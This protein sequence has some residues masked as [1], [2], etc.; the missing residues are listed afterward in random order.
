MREWSGLRRL[1]LQA[2]GR[3][4]DTVPSPKFNHE[5][6]GAWLSGENW[7]VNVTK[8]IIRTGDMVFTSLFSALKK[9]K[10]AWLII[11]AIS[12][13]T[14]SP[15]R[16][17]IINPTEKQVNE[18]LVYGKKHKDNIE[19]IK[20][21][22]SYP[23]ISGKEEFVAVVTKV[24]LLK[25]LSAYNEK[26]GQKLSEKDIEGIVNA[27]S[28]YIKAYLLGDDVDFAADIRGVIK[29]GDRVIQPVEVKPMVW[30]IPSLAWPQSP[31]YKA[32]NYYYFDYGEKRGDEK[33]TFILQKA[34]GEKRFEIDL[35]KYD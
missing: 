29:I 24:S 21:E 5:L 11:T 13:I 25:L 12:L 3:S 23:L 17:M 27:K 7:F 4:R 19:K 2:K 15:S 14:A 30:A 18:A 16:A 10:I 8:N 31:S 34:E 22:Y 6:Y 33:I 20:Q 32:A 28:F 1:L 26:R 35:S 9:N